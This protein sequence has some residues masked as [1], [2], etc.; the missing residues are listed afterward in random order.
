MVGPVA[1]RTFLPVAGRLNEQSTPVAS[2]DDIRRAITLCLLERRPCVL[3]MTD[4][5]T[6]TSTLTTPAALRAFSVDGGGRWAFVVA[7]SMSTLFD[8]KASPSTFLNLKINVRTGNAVQVL[9]KPSGSPVI[10]EGVDVDAMLGTATNLFTSS[11][12]GSSDTVIMQTCTLRGVEHF[13]QSP[14]PTGT[15]VN[16]RIS[17]VR[18]ISKSA[19]LVTIGQGATSPGFDSC[20]LERITGDISVDLG[21]LSNLSVFD[22]LQGNG[23]TSTFST[24]NSGN[25]QVLI[26]VNGFASSST[27]SADTIVGNALPVATVPTLNSTLNSAGPTLTPGAASYVRVTHGAGASGIVTVSGA[28][29]VNGRPVVLRFVTV[30]GAAVYTDGSGNLRLASNFTPTADDTLTLVWDSTASLWYE[31]ARSVN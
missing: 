24:S 6:I 10:I 25:P 13:V 7:A 27:T 22:S 15:F 20:R 2:M 3:T 29:A 4:N 26:N 31:I 9:F 5:I 11:D 19:A 30:A 21:P 17:D 14:N 18:V 12:A 28:G 1:P 23:A 16:C 8:C